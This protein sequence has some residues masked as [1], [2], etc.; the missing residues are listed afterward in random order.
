[1]S[2]AKDHFPSLDLSQWSLSQRSL[3]SC[4]YMN[5][6]IPEHFLSGCSDHMVQCKPRLIKQIWIY[7]VQQQIIPKLRNLGVRS[8]QFAGNIHSSL[9]SPLIMF[10]IVKF[11]NI[12]SDQFLI[13]CLILRASKNY[14]YSHLKRLVLNWKPYYLNLSLLTKR[15]LRLCIMLSFSICKNCLSI[16]SDSFLRRTKFQPSNFVHGAEDFAAE[17]GLFRRTKGATEFLASRQ[18]TVTEQVANGRKAW[19]ILVRS[20]TAQATKVPQWLQVGLNFVRFW[21]C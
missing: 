20:G 10:Y 16:G 6:E 21:L 7:R 13:K 12:S 17:R 4:F 18:Q 11:E 9:F 1:V 14:R 2:V 5:A 3:K 8:A 15:I 19:T